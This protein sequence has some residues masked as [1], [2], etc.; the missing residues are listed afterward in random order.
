MPALGIS[1]NVA[2]IKISLGVLV[3]I[4]YPWYAHATGALTAT[5]GFDSTINLNS[6]IQYGADYPNPVF[7]FNTPPPTVQ[8][9]PPTFN[10][11][12]SLQ[13]QSGLEARLRATF[14]SEELLSASVSASGNLDLTVKADSQTFPAKTK[15]SGACLKPHFVEWGLDF[16]VTAA[17]EYNLMKDGSSTLPSLLPFCSTFP[18]L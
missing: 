5:A 13:A 10:A 3:D 17:G 4:K 6:A 15:G 2:G 7:T 18:A 16:F 14:V 9:H 1:V 8:L 12:A 11:N